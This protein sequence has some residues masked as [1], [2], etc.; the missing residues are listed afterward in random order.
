LSV[1][2]KFPPTLLHFTS[3]REIIDGS[4]EPADSAPR[5]SGRNL[6]PAGSQR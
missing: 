6:S 4:I 1:D 5:D 3:E 2:D